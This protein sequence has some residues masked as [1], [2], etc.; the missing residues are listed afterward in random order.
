MASIQRFVDP[1]CEKPF[2]YQTLEGE[3]LTFEYAEK[4]QKPVYMNVFKKKK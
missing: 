4:T 1:W 3:W 2:T